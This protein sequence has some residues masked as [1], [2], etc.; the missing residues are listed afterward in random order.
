MRL[1]ATR[2]VREPLKK[3]LQRTV[4]SLARPAPGFSE[5]TQ[6]LIRE[7]N[8]WSGHQ[9]NARLKDVVQRVFELGQLKGLQHII[10]TIPLR[11]LDPSSRANLLNIIG[12]VSRYREAARI[13]YRM[14]KKFPIARRYQIVTVSLPEDSFR[15]PSTAL[16]SAPP[17]TL[18]SVLARIRGGSSQP[19]KR[20]AKGT[21][22][23][24]CRL[25]GKS[26]QDANKKFISQRTQ[27]L[28]EAKIHA[29]VQL[30][31]HYDTQHVHPRP[32]VICSSKD[33]C[34][35]C[36]VFIMLHG[37]FHIPKSHGRLYSGWRTQAMTATSVGM[38]ALVKRLEDQ[39][40][41]SIIVMMARRQRIFYP[42]PNESTLLTIPYSI[43]TVEGSGSSET[44]RPPEDQ[45]SLS[46]S[47]DS[48]I[49][50]EKVAQ[51]EAA[52]AIPQVEAA[53]VAE[54]VG[55][56]DPAIK[57]GGAEEIIN[58]P[59]DALLQDQAVTCEL[60]ANGAPHKH[61]AWPLS[62]EVEYTV[63]P[64]G[65]LGG[66]ISDVA[67]VKYSLTWLSDQHK[68]Q[69][70]KIEDAKIIEGDKIKDEIQLDPQDL[71]NLYISVGKTVLKFEELQ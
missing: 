51:T 21:I 10:T 41:R 42:D 4:D 23:E 9:T 62:L 46:Q 59:P 43:S 69:V 12:K 37:K 16:P 28:Q 1:V 29:E 33:A 53:E 35:L 34:Y 27:I 14:A 3:L 11:S 17:A 48:H 45:S 71:R 64:G 39:V 57:D 18:A 56:K 15:R 61:H 5:K 52:E 66:R 30:A 54:L 13:L 19:A 68:A 65:P 20:K 7:L 70:G 32:R 36:N 67:K 47:H 24:I 25:L 50:S 44:L 26:E 38:D 60:E 2:N 58:R 31:H 22:T 49:L 8:A 63:G 40:Q 55:E 6:N